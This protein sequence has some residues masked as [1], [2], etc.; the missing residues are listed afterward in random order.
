M[1]QTMISIRMDEN[2]KKDME[3]ICQ[4]LGLNMTTAFTI[5]AKQMVR[6]KKIPF[7]VSAM[8]NKEEMDSMSIDEKMSTVANELADEFECEHVITRNELQSIMWQRFNVAPG[9]VIPS[10]Y[11]YNRL[12]NGITL[13]KPTLFK[14]LGGGK[15]LCLGEGYCYNGPIFHRQRGASVDDIVG[16]CIDGERIPDY[17]FWEDNQK[18]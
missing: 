8:T 12:N 4:E 7:E 3:F 11:C 1:A 13:K 10:D 2:L 15:Y 9:S 17:P 14:F 6:E 18:G 16:Q 5:F